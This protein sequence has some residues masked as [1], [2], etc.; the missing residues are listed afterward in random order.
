MSH[1]K[2]PFSEIVLHPVWDLEG[3]LGRSHARNLG[4][5]EMVDQGIDW[6]FFLDADDIMDRDCFK[7]VADLLGRYDAV[8]GLISEAPANAPRSHQLRK[9]QLESTE[10]LLDILNIPPFL[11]LQMGHFVRAELAQKIGFDVTMD[12]GEDFKYYLQ[13]WS[14]YRCAKVPRRFF[15][16]CRG[17]HSTGPRSATGLQWSKTVTQIIKQAKIALLG[18][19]TSRWSTLAGRTAV[20]VA[21]PSEEVLWAGGLL[22]DQPGLDV[23]VCSVPIADPKQ[24]LCFFDA[25]RQLRQNPI[26]IPDFDA[27]PQIPLRLLDLLPL[28]NYDT[29]FTHEIVGEN[30]P[31]HHRQIHHHIKTHFRGTVFTFATKGNEIRMGLDPASQARKLD[32]VRAYDRAACAA[33]SRALEAWLTGPHMELGAETYNVGKLPDASQA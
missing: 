29:I 28:G 25:M 27:G 19:L 11:T 4:I 9:N 22:S 7:N 31:L 30:V 17:N 15:I 16:N 10:S 5:K 1:S 6:I 13:L 14:S 12:T 32:L 3:K 8:W 21:H 20:V 33:G 18:Q 24:M 23:I 26:V 2:G